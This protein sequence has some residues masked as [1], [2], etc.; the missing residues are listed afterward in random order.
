MRCQAKWPLQH[1]RTG[2]PEY[3]HSTATV[4]RS[5]QV[6]SFHVRNIAHPATFSGLN[7]IALTVFDAGAAPTPTHSV[8]VVANDGSQMYATANDTYIS[9][10]DWQRDGSVPTSTEVHEFTTAASGVS[11]YVC[12]GSVDGTLLSSYSMSEDNGVL[13]VATRLA[14]RAAGSISTKCPAA[15]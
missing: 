2:V 4:Q 13:R 6:S 8:G 7:T 15:M 14:D 5:R 3:S 1:F 9:S 10:T 12:S 11:T